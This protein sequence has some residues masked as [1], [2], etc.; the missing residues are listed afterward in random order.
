MRSILKLSDF[1]ATG[2]RTDE[3]K[4]DCRYRFNRNRSS[5]TRAFPSEA[6]GLPESVAIILVFL[7]PVTYFLH[8][9]E[10][11]ALPGG[12]AEWNKA[13]R[14][15]FAQ[16]MTSRPLQGQRHPGNCGC[17]VPLGVF[18]YVGG[19]SFWGFGHGMLSC[20]SWCS[21]PFTIFEVQFVQTSIVP[22]WRLVLCSMF[23]LPSLPLRTSWRR[24]RWISFHSLSALPSDRCSSLFSIISK[25]AATKKRVSQAR[26][27]IGIAGQAAVI[28]VM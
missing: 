15:K 22:A 3:K 18:D 6:A 26:S 25:S 20:L 17:L 5:G 8:I 2:R 9:L 27:T 13:Y 19:Y 11:F 14:P 1:S 12:F 10:E 16:A 21:M 4:I 23:L 24:A 28:S 7:L